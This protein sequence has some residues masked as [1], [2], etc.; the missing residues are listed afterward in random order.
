MFAKDFHRVL[1]H[2]DIKVFRVDELVADLDH[3]ENSEVFPTHFHLDEIVDSFV[4][5]LDQ[6]RPLQEGLADEGQSKLQDVVFSE[7]NLQ[8]RDIV[9]AFIDV[10]KQDLLEDFVFVV[11]PKLGGHIFKHAQVQVIDP[12]LQEIG[13]VR[14]R[15]FL[16]D[17]CLLHADD[18]GQYSEILSV[19][20]LPFIGVG[21]RLGFLRFR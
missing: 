11:P 3:R 4:V 5:L 12:L 8:Q 14:L 19:D 16:C 21:L 13:R 2:R 20:E 17:D 6:P 10:L 15:V 9:R 1:V 7:Q 18:E